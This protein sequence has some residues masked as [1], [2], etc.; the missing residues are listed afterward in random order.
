MAERIHLRLKVLH[1]IE[2]E[3]WTLISASFPREEITQERLEELIS[4]AFIA[5]DGDIVEIES[6]VPRRAAK[7]CLAELEIH[8]DFSKRYGGNGFGIAND[9]DD[10]D[11]T[12][13]YKDGGLEDCL[14]DFDLECILIKE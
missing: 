8:G 13:D 6:F 9:P 11:G 1:F 14:L 2:N 7:E 5:L 4:D 12:K 3:T 10:A